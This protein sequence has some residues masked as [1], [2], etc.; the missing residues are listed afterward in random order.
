MKDS[1]HTPL[2][3]L[4]TVEGTSVPTSALSSNE[5]ATV[6]D[7]SIQKGHVAL[8]SVEAPQADISAKDVSLDNALLVSSVVAAIV[9]PRVL[10]PQARAIVQSGTE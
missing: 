6:G 5:T 10:Q 2:H 7:S 1:D 9:M 4:S 3:K 8:L